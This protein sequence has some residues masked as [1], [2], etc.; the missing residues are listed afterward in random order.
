MNPTLAIYTTQSNT[1]AGVIEILAGEDLTGKEGHI[2]V[3]THDTGVPEVQ[4]PAAVSDPVEYL[5]VR[6]AADGELC[7]VYPITR[8]SDIRV[9][10]DGTCNP[11]DQLFLAAIDGTHDGMVQDEPAGAG[12]YSAVLRAEEAG[13]DNQMVSCRLMPGPVSVT[14]SE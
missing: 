14:V 10:L 3:L 5:L 8:E 12:T 9:K 4:L 13:V 6:G 2:V 7:S 1:Q 11:G